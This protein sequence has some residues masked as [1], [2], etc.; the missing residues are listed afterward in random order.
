[1][2]KQGM[3]KQFAT[4]ELLALEDLEFEELAGIYVREIPNGR[5]NVFI[6]VDTEKFVLEYWMYTPR[7]H[8]DYY[9][10]FTYFEDLME[11]IR[12]ARV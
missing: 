1:M 11:V 5:I 3:S 7:P 9:K 10:Q 4:D 6:D 2:G 12:G 8:T